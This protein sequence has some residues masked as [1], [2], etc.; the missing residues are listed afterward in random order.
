MKYMV[1]NAIFLYAP[2]VVTEILT[3]FNTNILKPFTLM[4]IIIYIYIYIYTI[5]KKIV[6]IKLN[7]HPGLVGEREKGKPKE[8]FK[9][10]PVSAHKPEKLFVDAKAASHR[11]S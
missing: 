7:L 3:I 1:T 5:N 2:W 4:L 10:C 8:C 11:H 6:N 9:I